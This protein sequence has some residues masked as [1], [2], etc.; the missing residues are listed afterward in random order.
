MIAIIGLLLFVVTSAIAL[1]RKTYLVIPFMTVPILAGLACGF[2]FNDVMKFAATG[3][4]SVFNA[5]LLCIFAV[6]YFSVLSETGMFDIIV[7]KLVR[8][9]KGNIYIIMCVTVLVAFIGHLDGAYITT[10]VVSIPALA[11]LYKRMKID[12]K[13]LVLLIA[14]AATPM[15]AMPWGNPVKIAVFDKNLDPVAMSQ[16]LYPVLGCMLLLAFLYAVGCAYFW[17]RKNG[18]EYESMRASI[19]AEKSG[20]KVDFSNKPF[21]R[22]KRFWMNLLLFAFSM[23][24]FVFVTSVKTYLLFMLFSAI[25]LVLN[26]DA[27]GQGDIVRKYAPMMLAPSI[28]FMGIGIMIGV[29]DGTGM[30]KQM[31]DIMLSVVPASLARYTNVLWGILAMPIGVVV[32]YQALMSVSPLLLGIGHACGLNSYQVLSY[33][34]MAYLNPASPVVAANNIAAELAGVDII[35][36]AKYS[37]LPVFIFNTISVLLCFAFGVA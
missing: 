8:I 35:D 37:F 20:S 28:L 9:T 1:S 7:D 14:L 10:F 13:L 12:P 5:V 27:K 36:L 3:V 19:M 15:C 22:P 2:S 21:A 4:D 33:Q 30:V 17:K 24:V 29:L 31:V 34:C 26:Y 32:P 16:G 18:S 23:G 11:P 6:L 25:A